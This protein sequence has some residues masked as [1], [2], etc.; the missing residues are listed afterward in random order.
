V[1]RTENLGDLDSP[2]K[3]YLE[4]L[5]A[6]S[7]MNL[8]KNSVKQMNKADEFLEAAIY[9]LYYQYLNLS[10]KN[11]LGDLGS[12]SKQDLEILYS[13]NKEYLE[14]L[15]A[16]SR[17]NLFRYCIKQMNE[18]DFLEAAKYLSHHLKDSI[19]VKTLFF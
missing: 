16:E 5:Q 15:R 1:P 10:S 11:V 9:L 4:M 7:R 13:P 8:F 14:T 17:M 2:I 18:D 6:E 3:E 12:P 19:E